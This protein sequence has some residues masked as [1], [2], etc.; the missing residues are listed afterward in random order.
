MCASV[1]CVRLIRP[2][3]PDRPRAARPSHSP[4]LRMFPTELKTFGA[5]LA[6]A[7]D[8]ITATSLALFLSCFCLLWLSTQFGARIL[9]R[10][11]PAGAE[12]GEDF[13]M[14]LGA[15]LSLLGLI[16]GFTLS[17]AISGFNS[18]QAGEEA[19]AGAI[20]TAYLRADL[21]PQ[22]EGEH[23]RSMLSAY[24]GERLRF[25][26]SAD[27]RA[28]AESRR[29]AQELQD[30][31]WT[32]TS[33]AAVAQKNPITSLVVAGVN[34]VLSAQQ[35]TYAGWRAQIPLAAWLLLTT[36]AVFCNA[37]V[38]YN[39]RH[40]R[41]RAG[42]FLV[43]PMTISLSFLVISEID[44]P[45]RGIIRVKPVNLHYVSEVTSARAAV[46]APIEPPRP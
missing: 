19:E 21:L 24:L 6:Q 23:L 9:G 15:T 28:Y 30:D 37:L 26:E 18:R 29:A 32:A 45:G 25:Y 7:L 20:R 43:L 10:R 14:I 4:D 35:K 17:M 41:R 44:V 34:E 27:P 42:L 36:I 38:G 1:G 46:L 31:L 12:G 39:A 11:T 13:R 33:A 16:I 3:R 22:A 2:A 5:S 40:L 8:G